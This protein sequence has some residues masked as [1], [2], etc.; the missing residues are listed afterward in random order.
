MGRRTCP[1]AATLKV[2][3]IM[4]EHNIIFN[5]I[6]PALT[7]KYCC[8][9]SFAYSIRIPMLVK[10]RTLSRFGDAVQP[11]LII[12]TLKLNRNLK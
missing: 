2:S 10:S 7:R 11:A 1:L 6:V 9:V 12:A 4:E 8:R 5:T 3:L